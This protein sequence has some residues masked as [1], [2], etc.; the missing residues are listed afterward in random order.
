MEA[1]GVVEE[2]DLFGISVAFDNIVE[3]TISDW[4]ITPVTLLTR[5]GGIIGVGKELLWVI[6]LSFSSITLLFKYINNTI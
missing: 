4:Q 3:Q 2:K 5:I 6:L 1:T